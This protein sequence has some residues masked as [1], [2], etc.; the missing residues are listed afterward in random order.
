VPKK[1]APLAKDL[2][3]K[4]TEA[5]GL[6]W[7][8]L[9]TKHL[10][11][12]KFRRQQPIGNF[13]VDFVCFE[14]III[15]ELDGGQHAL[16]PEKDKDIKRDLWFEVQGYKVLRFWDNEVLSKTEAV[17]ETIWAHSLSHP[18]LVPLPSREGK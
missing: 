18:P 13:I 14:K 2:R 15:I 8:H 5:E 1:L 17:L 9:R 11:G 6:L 12:L 16:Q 10:R 7:R 3:K 4:E